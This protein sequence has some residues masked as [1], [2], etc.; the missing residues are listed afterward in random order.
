MYMYFT[1]EYENPGRF[2]NPTRR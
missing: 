2:G 1:L